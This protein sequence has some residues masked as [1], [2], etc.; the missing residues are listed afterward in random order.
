[1]ERE[2]KICEYQ[3][4]KKILQPKYNKHL[5]K[6]WIHPLRR[7]CDGICQNRSVTLR[8]YYRNRDSKKYVEKNKQRFKNWYK[9][10]KK[11]HFELVY[12]NYYK[13]RIEWNERKYVNVHKKKIWEIIGRVCVDCG[14]KAIQVNHK[15]YDFPSR[16]DFK[17]NDSRLKKYIEDYCKFLEPLCKECHAKRRRKKEI[18][19]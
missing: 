18:K 9:N 15:T 6:Y 13:N 14:K 1:M 8:Y 10:N 12:K 3:S 11:R 2:I 16:K 5:K 17:K 19:N 4:C 7:F